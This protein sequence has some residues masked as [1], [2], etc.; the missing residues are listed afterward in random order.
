MM[1]AFICERHVFVTTSALWWALFT[2]SIDC[3]LQ[4]MYK[5]GPATKA[6]DGG[7]KG[8]NCAFFEFRA[9]IDDEAVKLV[10]IVAVKT[11]RRGEEFHVDYGD[12]RNEYTI[13]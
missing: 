2:C 8:S 11:I 9:K 6:N 10:F 12:R 4:N 7:S 5:F 13:E 1:K 3:N